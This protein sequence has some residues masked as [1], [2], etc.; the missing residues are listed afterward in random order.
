MK[1][2][3]GF[4]GLIGRPNVG[5]STLINLLVGQKIAI[6]TSVAQTTRHRIKGVVTNDK[7]QIIFLDTPGFSKSLDKLGN[8][9]TDEGK[10]ALSES[11]AFVMVVDMSEIAGKGDEWVAEQLKKTGRHI[12][13]VMNKVDLCQSA[14]KRQHHRDTYLHLFGDYPKFNS[15]Q[16]SAKTGKNHQKIVE[17]LMRKLPEGPKYYDDDAVT[18]QRMREMSAEIIREKVLL[19][20]QEEIP[21][22]VA[23]GIETF[24]ESEK[25]TRIT[26]T[27]YVDQTSQK[28][29]LIGKNGQLIKKIGTEARVD[30]ETLLEQRV[31]LELN[32]KVRQNWRKDPKFL[33]SLGLAPPKD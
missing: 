24:E 22:S 10:A 8:F 33:A 19:N 17:I 15:L 1:F 21:H 29:I 23:I 12:L 25:M 3:S 30:I 11:D 20:T 13:L 18:D 9:L 28:P 27:L 2:R 4:V 7:G 31:Y 6:A 5:K 16:V 14:E 32:V 26:S